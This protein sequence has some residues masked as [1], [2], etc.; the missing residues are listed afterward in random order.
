MLLNKCHGVEDFE[1]KVA[2]HATR[3]REMTYIYFISVYDK[4]FG[5]AK[6]AGIFVHPVMA[7]N[8]FSYICELQILRN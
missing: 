4:K 6:T 2:R 8:D 1:D 5:Y 7:E 3:M